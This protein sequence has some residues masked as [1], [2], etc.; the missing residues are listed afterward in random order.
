MK[1][2]RCVGAQRQAHV[3]MCSAQFTLIM[4]SMI[5]SLSFTIYMTN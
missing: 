2:Q 5:V 4:G 3:G 1:F